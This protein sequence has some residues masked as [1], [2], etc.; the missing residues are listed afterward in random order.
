MPKFLFLHAA[1]VCR[2]F[3]AKRPPQ[4]FIFLNIIILPNPHENQCWSACVLMSNLSNNTSLLV[5][6]VYDIQQS[7]KYYI[8]KKVAQNRQ[9]I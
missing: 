3:F 9:N 2:D 8:R 7:G 5:I 4:A 1:F 6:Y